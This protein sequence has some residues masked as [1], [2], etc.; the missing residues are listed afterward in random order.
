MVDRPGEADVAPVGE[1]QRD[2]FRVLRLGPEIQLVDH[3]VADLA[4]HPLEPLERHE[5]LHRPEDPLQRPQV[6]ARRLLDV[7]VLHLH[8]HLLPGVEARDV[9]LPDRG[10]GDGALGELGEQL[11]RPLAQLVADPA[12]D[13]GERPRRDRVL[14]PRQ[15][16][17][18]LGRQ[19]VGHDA[20]QL[21]HL[22]EQ[23]LQ[24]EDRPV[25][26]A[27][28]AQVLLHQDP[29]GRGARAEPTEQAR[30]QI[31]HQHHRG[32]PVRLDLA[33]GPGGRAR[34]RPRQ[35]HRR[36]GVVPEGGDARQPGSRLH[37]KDDTA[38]ACPMPTE[39]DEREEREDERSLRKRLEAFV[40]DL[41][42]KTFYAGL[43]AV[44]T[45]EE[46]IR[47]I[48]SEFSLPKDVVNYLV[49]S[50]G[51]T[52]DELF[53]IVGRELRQFLESLNI[54][55]EVAK[56]LTTLSFEI[57]TEIRFIPNDES[58]GGVKPQIKPTMTV[59][60]NEPEA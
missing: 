18:E 30:A 57:K 16:L 54:S 56:L 31:A 50:A 53:R 26:A 38:Y 7:R 49:S 27:R 48:A 55:Q 25:D 20:D 44:F 35:R 28:V 22:D 51:S 34:V 24:V 33:P 59:K 23:S 9:H 3:H 2:A 14:E 52:K 11:A 32:D 39:D 58:I 12:L 6:G 47:K 42:K 8:R 36:A 37:E 60:K 10:G 41:V 29:L 43:G 13:V 15:L 17:P 40:P 19:E 45:T 21:S 1:V 5:I 4:K 46:G